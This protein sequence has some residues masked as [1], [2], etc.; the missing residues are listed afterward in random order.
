M[1]PSGSVGISSS[2]IRTTLTPVCSPN[3]GTALAPDDLTTFVLAPWATRSAS[4]ASDGKSPLCSASTHGHAAQHLV[5][6]R[7]R[8]ERAV[9]GRDRL[10][11]RQ[12]GHGAVE[13]PDKHRRIVA[14]ALEGGLGRG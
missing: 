1:R 11:L 5:D 2:P 14:R 4:A 3:A 12:V 13:S 9:T 8:I 10:Q 7:R 6:V